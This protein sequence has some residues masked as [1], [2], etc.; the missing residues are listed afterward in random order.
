MVDC[1]SA[2]HIFS[3][4]LNLVMD[5]QIDIIVGIFENGT[6]LYGMSYLLRA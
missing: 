1:E 4:C 6:L 3:G 5:L 2:F